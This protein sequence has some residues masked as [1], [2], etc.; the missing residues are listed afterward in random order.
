MAGKDLVDCAVPGV[1]EPGTAAYQDAL[2]AWQNRWPLQP[3]NMVAHSFAALTH[4]TLSAIASE[5]R[6]R[7]TTREATVIEEDVSVTIVVDK[8]HAC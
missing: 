1:E 2:L 7:E 6:R 4:S 5:E 3:K 8:N